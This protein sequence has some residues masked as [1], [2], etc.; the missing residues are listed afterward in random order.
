MAIADGHVDGGVKFDAADFRAGQV[1]LGVDMVD[2]AVFNGGKHAAQ[3]AY[4]AGLA[5]VMDFAVPHRVGADGLLAPAV[6]LSDEGAVP[7]GLGAILEFV[8]GP[9]VVVAL[10]EVFAQGDAGALGLGHVAVFNY[11]A[12]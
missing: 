8:G 12:L 6:Q 5:A 7:L 11:P 3:V 4:D 1:A 9:F 2:M 10:L